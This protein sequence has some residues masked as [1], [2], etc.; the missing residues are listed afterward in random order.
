MSSRRRI[1]NYNETEPVPAVY[2]ATGFGIGCASAM[3]C[4][5]MTLLSNRGFKNTGETGAVPHQPSC[6]LFH[7]RVESFDL[8]VCEFYLLELGSCRYLYWYSF[9][10]C[11]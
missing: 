11:A 7:G 4:Q 8:P 5:M 3:K 9:P 2:E 1:E 6:G 10:Y